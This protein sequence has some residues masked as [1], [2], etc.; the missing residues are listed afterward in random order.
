[1]NTPA[2]S[3]F[4]LHE[5]SSAEM[6][7]A[8]THQQPSGFPSPATDYLEERINL[9]RILISNPTSTYLARIQGGAHE[10]TGLQEGDLL[11]IDRS[12]T[13]RSGKLVLVWEDQEFTVKFLLKQGKS[14][15]LTSRATPSSKDRIP[16]ESGTK[17][18]GVVTQWIRAV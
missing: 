11:L 8:K 10:E 18:W 14:Y 1:M 7:A 16:V 9:S 4:L 6:A 12:I 13:P 17:I 3:L 5:P 15:F 2:L